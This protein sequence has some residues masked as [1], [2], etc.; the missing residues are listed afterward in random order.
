ME[1]SD[2]RIDRRK[3]LAGL[4]TVGL[5]TLLAACA[6]KEP[7]TSAAVPTS[8][9]SMAT[10]QPQTT[11]SATDLFDNAGTCTITAEQ[12]EGPYYFDVDAIR[13]DIREDRDGVPLRLAIRVQHATACTPIS[14]AVVDIWHCDAGGL[15][16]GFESASQGG[17]GGS[18][19]DQKTYLRG[20]QVT[21][22]NG[23][24]EFTTVYPGWYRGRTVHIHTKVHLT[25][26]S[27]LT[28]QLYFDENVTAAVYQQ[29]PY[30]KHTGRDT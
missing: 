14:N 30:N 4:G 27:V 18:R 21:N 26:S 25:T 1:R 10:V 13:S 15:Y 9:G 19:T 22:A 29:S 23:V 3:A 12:T 11:A 7:T 5:G 24:V 28:T 17:P 6:G 20:A 8:T 2:R 16:S